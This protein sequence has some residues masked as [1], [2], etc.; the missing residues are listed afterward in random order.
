M[1]QRRLVALGLVLLGL[2]TAASSLLGPL[3]F[4]VIRWR[5]TGDMEDQLIGGD[6]VGLLLVA[7]VALVAAVLW[8]RGRRLAPALALGPALYGLYSYLVAIL[9]PEYERYPGNNE[10]FFPLYLGL[11]LLSW[12]IA[13]QAW[14]AIAS[15]ELPRLSRRTRRQLAAPLILVGG[16]M[17]LA[18][19]G[20][21]ATV[22]GGHTSRTGYLD[23]PTG[24]WLIRTFDLAFVIPLGIATG[25]GLLRDRPPATKAAF[26]VLGFLTLMTASVAGMAIAMLVRD[27]ADATL[28]F[29]AVLTPAAVLLG[30]LTLRLFRFY[31]RL[32]SGAAPKPHA[33]PSFA[34]IT[35]DLTHITEGGR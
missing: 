29:P 3:G 13:A 35:R 8:W 12:T 25:V 11:T 6:I 9:I 15:A 19:L 7:P 2:G 24:F 14:S 1:W 18:W 34:P 16:M 26:G 5:I 23:H 32:G 28:I 21:V 31:D 17:G 33:A 30:L 10:R 22:M 4:D 20:Q 27:S